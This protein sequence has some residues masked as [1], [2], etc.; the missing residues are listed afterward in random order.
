MFGEVEDEG[1]GVE[2]EE[3][4]EDLEKQGV[5]SVHAV[6]FAL[7]LCPLLFSLSVSPLGEQ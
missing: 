6:F 1:D 7:S 3:E 2:G 4:D 5:S